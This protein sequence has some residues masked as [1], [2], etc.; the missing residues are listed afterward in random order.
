MLSQVGL[1]PNLLSRKPAML[2][3]GQQQRVAL[4]RA[5]I[6]CPDILLCD[7][8]T[9]AVD[10]PTRM[11][12]VKL[13]QHLQRN[14]G[15]AL[16]IIT[17]DLTLPKPLGGTLMVIDQGRVVEQGRVSE[18]LARPAHEVTRQLIGAAQLTTDTQR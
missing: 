3:G 7:E 16:L 9:S 6:S 8:V 18:L 12:L 4:A 14:Q 2:S 13:L 15:I 17:H 1:E 10:G 5:L 11:E